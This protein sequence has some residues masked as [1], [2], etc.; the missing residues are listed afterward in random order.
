MTATCFIPSVTHRHMS[1]AC[2]LFSS[3][4]SVGETKLVSYA[5]E[6]S[7]A[8]E[9][10]HNNSHSLGCF[11]RPLNPRKG[12]GVIK[13]DVTRTREDEQTFIQDLQNR[14]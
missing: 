7:S 11:I 5:L 3:N 13:V 10:N 4:K 14:V 8:R 1:K 9:L 6:A 2:L 12:H